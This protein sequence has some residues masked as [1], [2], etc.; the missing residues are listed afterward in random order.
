MEILKI[1]HKDYE[2]IQTL[3]DNAFVCSKNNQKFLVRKYEP[4]TDEGNALESD[5][6]YIKSNGIPAP[7]LIAIDKKNGY[8]VNEYI[9]GETALSYLA[10]EDFNE[11]LYNQLFKAQF[12]AKLAKITLMY[13]PEKWMISK[14]KLYYVYPFF[15]KY[16]PN[17]ELSNNLKLFFNTKDLANLC[18]KNGIFYDKNRIKD[19]YS[20]NKYIMEMVV[21]YYR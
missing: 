20:T 3:S 14:G 12:M 15:L 8:T 6:K 11:D 2:I 19:E 7:K 4:K 9:E 18:K 1:K 16:D 5:L 10:R 21:K 17:F 13:S